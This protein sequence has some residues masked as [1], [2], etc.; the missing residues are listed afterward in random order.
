MFTVR[1]RY[2]AQPKIYGFW[3]N[4]F[5]CKY[6]WHRGLIVIVLVQILY[7]DDFLIKN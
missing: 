3:G 5:D 7:G 6:R 1:N 4:Q 2:V